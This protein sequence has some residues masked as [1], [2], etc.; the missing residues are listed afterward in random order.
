MMDP[1]HAA[2][3]D[4]LWAQGGPAA[5]DTE[6]ERPAVRDVLMLRPIPG[7]SDTE[8]AARAVRCI[9]CFAC[10][11]RDADWTTGTGNPGGGL[12][13]CT[14][15][16]A[17]HVLD[18]TFL[19]VIE[20]G[21]RGYLV[22]I[23]ERLRAL[24]TA[25][26]SVAELWIRGLGT[27][28]TMSC[29]SAAALQVRDLASRVFTSTGIP[30][31]S[32]AEA[33]RQP[34]DVMTTRPNR[35]VVV[36]G[37]IYAAAGP[38]SGV[39]SRSIYEPVL[40]AFAPQ[41]Y[42]RVRV[43][44]YHMSDTDRAAGAVGFFRGHEARAVVGIEN[45]AAAPVPRP[46]VPRKSAKTRCDMCGQPARTLYGNKITGH[47]LCGGCARG[48]LALR[49]PE[50]PPPRPA[51]KKARPGAREPSGGRFIDT[52]DGDPEIRP[53]APRRCG[54]DGV[55]CNPAENTLQIESYQYIHDPLR[56]HETADSEDEDGSCDRWGAEEYEIWTTDQA[57]TREYFEEC[58]GKEEGPVL[59][60][61]AG[62]PIFAVM[63]DGWG[64]LALV[65]R[66]RVAGTTLAAL[67]AF[68]ERDP[69]Y[70]DARCLVLTAFRKR[71]PDPLLPQT[72]IKPHADVCAETMEEL[73]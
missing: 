19:N 2:T 20:F 42:D 1:G 63:E 18:L 71:K 72:W 49:R 50:S 16:C 33:R 25:P 28:C 17:G 48:E 12:A 37:G 9:R 53:R 69:G 45:D 5:P 30:H 26:T 47:D 73:P 3:F 51:T 35:V 70:P 60:M 55:C 38:P 31:I 14:E 68:L 40:A 52:G 65:D 58:F 36:M 41:I 62:A 27:T 6:P 29:S 10:G 66:T 43:L 57:P 15:S 64:Q 54:G 7:E 11:Q 34:A 56:A 4:A 32:A 67:L 8:F 39:V 44:D 24:A 46:Q 21:T 61:A 23:I 13:N 22:P 59:F